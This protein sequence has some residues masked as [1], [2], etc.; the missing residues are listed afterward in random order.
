MVHFV[1]L[2]LKGFSNKPRK[3]F[4]DCIWS[5]KISESYF[6]EFVYMN[7]K[8]I[9]NNLKAGVAEITVPKFVIKI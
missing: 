7:K 5:S 8:K 4:I 3:F 1:E 6:T 9:Q 2:V